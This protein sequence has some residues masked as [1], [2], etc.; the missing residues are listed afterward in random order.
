MFMNCL[1]ANSMVSA[2]HFIERP[3][4]YQA[5]HQWALLGRQILYTFWQKNQNVSISHGFILFF[6]VSSPL[7]A[8][9]HAVF[10]F[11]DVAMWVKLRLANRFLP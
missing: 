2:S 8:C 6:S 9:E 1:K 11:V 7:C 4:P 10:V 5:C 3:K